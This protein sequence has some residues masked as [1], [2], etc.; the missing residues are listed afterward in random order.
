M[1]FDAQYY[2]R[3]YQDSH[4]RVADPGYY[5]CLARFIA[6]YSAMLDISVASIL[7][8]G[9]GTGALRKPLLEQFERARYEGVERSSY[10]CDRYGWTRGCASDFSSQR[11][12]DLI[13]CH[14]VMQYL[15]AKRAAKALANFRQLTNKLLYFSVLTL[16]DW[17]LNVDQNLTDGEVHLRS[18]AWYRRRLKPCFKNLGGGMYLAADNSAVVYA[19]EGGF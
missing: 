4:T 5:R 15:D 9:C 13:I 18:A 2:R 7:D 19:L 17:E 11:R 8:L 12:Y 3:Y 6:S 1:R 16:E 14:D 10:A